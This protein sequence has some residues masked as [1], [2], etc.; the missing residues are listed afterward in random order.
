MTANTQRGDDGLKPDGTPYR[1]LVVDDSVIMRKILR[2]VLGD[3]QY[4]ICG[5]AEDGGG[6]LDLYKELRPDVVTLDIFMD[7]VDGLSVLKDIMGFDKSAKILMLS[8]AEEKK[9]II[10]A[11]SMGARDY[12]VKPPDRQ[13]LLEKIRKILR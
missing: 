3:E 4:E 2:K 1:V 9:A 13:I 7:Q 10:K 8:G 11:I 5:E 12:V 6:V